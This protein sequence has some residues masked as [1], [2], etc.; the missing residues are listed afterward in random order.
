M[1][2]PFAATSRG[3]GRLGSPSA[4]WSSWWGAD[5]TSLSLSLSLLKP[6]SAQADE[7]VGVPVPAGVAISV[8]MV[9]DPFEPST[10]ATVA[11]TGRGEGDGE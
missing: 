3:A 10:F 1:I 9:A 11:D 8:A 6:A 4:R 7:S 5:S 2:L